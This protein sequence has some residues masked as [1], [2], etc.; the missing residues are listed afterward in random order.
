VAANRAPNIAERLAEVTRA[1]QNLTTTAVRN[2]FELTSFAIT[3]LLDALPQHQSIHHKD[4]HIDAHYLTNRTKG[5]FRHTRECKDTTI[6]TLIS[7]FNHHWIAI[8]FFETEKVVLIAD[9]IP[10]F[11]NEQ[12]QQTVRA[13]LTDHEADLGLGWTIHNKVLIQQ[14]DSENCGV[15]AVAFVRSLVRW[16]VGWNST[17]PATIDMIRLRETFARLLLLKY[18]LDENLATCQMG[19]VVGSPRNGC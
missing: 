2:S 17:V 19:D 10:G 3:E 1:V 18:D 9:S 15:L 11:T 13:I 12:A 6:W 8:V 4:V 16:L 7:Q 5:L 14:N